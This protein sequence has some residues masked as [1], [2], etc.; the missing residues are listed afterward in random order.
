MTRKL[1]RF[2]NHSA[3][4]LLGALFLVNLALF[5]LPHFPGSIPS[6]TM[7]APETR[8]P[9]MRIVYDANALY[10]FLT[11]IGVDGR[12]AFQIM[13]ATTDFTFPL[14]YGLFFFL[15]FRR[16]TLTS[17]RQRRYLMFLAFLPTVFDFSENFTLIYL[18][19]R[20]PD[21]NQKMAAFVPIFTMGKF[22]CLAAIIILIVFLT[23]RVIKRKDHG[24]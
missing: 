19:D 7:H 17:L 2:I 23:I 1:H 16:F 22:I 3:V 8:I 13:H 4:F 9:D 24:K 5:Y 20:F 14:V 21:Y 12:Q 18:T 10:D 11:Q 6:I 15:L